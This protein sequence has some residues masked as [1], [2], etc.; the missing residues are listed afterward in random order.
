MREE[1]DE[2]DEGG[3]AD[4]CEAGAEYSGRDPPPPEE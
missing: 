1:E 4:E 2:E 3:G